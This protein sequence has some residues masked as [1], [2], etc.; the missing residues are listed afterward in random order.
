MLPPRSNTTGFFLMNAPTHWSQENSITYLHFVFLLLRQVRT[1][2]Q[3]ASL[4][5]SHAL[6]DSS[7]LSLS[8]AVMLHH[9]QC[10][11]ESAHVAYAGG[12][13][14][15]ET[16]AS[17]EGHSLVGL[18]GMNCLCPML[19]RYALAFLGAAWLIVQP[20]LAADFTGRVMG[21]IDGDPLE[22]LHHQRAE[23]IRLTG[24]EHRL[25]GESS[26][27]RHTRQVRRR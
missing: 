18:T 17:T 8:C 10:D 15:S 19:R 11:H 23:R 27:L 4:R 1:L 21:V 20:W 13:P 25:P 3:Y 14:K 26:S 12:R 2:L 7:L 9:L 5:G 6:L 16:L 24:I 22:V